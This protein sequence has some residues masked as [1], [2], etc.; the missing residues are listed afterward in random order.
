MRLKPSTSS[1]EQGESREKP[2]CSLRTRPR[3]ISRSRDDLEAGQ[4][5]TVFFY[6]PD[7]LSESEREGTIASFDKMRPV[8]E[9]CML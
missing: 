6:F 3:F 5:E 9:R 4:K 8:K 7:I 2:T 1:L